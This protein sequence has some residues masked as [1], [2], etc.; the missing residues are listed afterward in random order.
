MKIILTITRLSIA[1]LPLWSG[2]AVLGFLTVV[3]P[4]SPPFPDRSSLASWTFH[5][6]GTLTMATW[7]AASLAAPTFTGCRGSLVPFL[8]WIAPR[9][10][11]ASVLR[12]S[13]GW[14]ISSFVLQA[15]VVCC[16]LSLSRTGLD[17]GML[18]SQPGAST[19]SVLIALFLQVALF[20]LVTACHA[21]LGAWG[22][23]A[24][25]ACI[26]LVALVASVSRWGPAA[27]DSLLAPGLF[28]PLTPLWPGAGVS[29]TAAA[30]GCAA[31]WWIASAALFL[32]AGHRPGL[33]ESS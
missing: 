8:L 18:T 26:V 15:G 10:P 11:V 3:F 30:I 2:L 25:S 28:L 23:T 22:G 19:A 21:W 31:C 27:V 32:L 17:S 5:V 7:L 1:S 29:C 20:L 9:H 14:A 6:L 33:R 16:S 12:L 13:G 4:A 24:T